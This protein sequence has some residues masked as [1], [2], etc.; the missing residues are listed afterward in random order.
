MA[1][2]VSSRY[3]TAL[4]DLALEKNEIDKIYEDI[5]LVNST[6]K[7][8][9]NLQ[10]VL[11]SPM[12]TSEVKLS[13][14]KNTFSKYVC[15]DVIGFFTVVFSKNRENLFTEITDI[16]LAKVRDYKNLATAEVFSAKPLSDERISELTEK[17]SKKFNKQIEVK[18]EV[19]PA[20]IGGIKI[21][22]CGHLIDGTVKKQLDEIKKNMLE[23]RLA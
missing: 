13:I 14:L 5:T 23:I 17:L 6:F 15:E 1:Q 16:F 21:R 20:L 4:F 19:D 22:V 7:T 11:A 8:D 3:A 12:F 10:K 2:L 9:E 18:V